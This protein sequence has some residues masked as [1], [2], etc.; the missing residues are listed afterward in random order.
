MTEPEQ[1]ALR[2]AI[3]ALASTEPV[4][5]PLSPFV[6]EHVLV[7]QDVLLLLDDWTFE[8]DARPRVIVKAGE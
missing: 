4:D 8:A 6:G 5:D 7:L 2:A 3:V 1:R